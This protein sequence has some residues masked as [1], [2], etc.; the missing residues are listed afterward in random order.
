MEFPR[1]SR[2]RVYV[3]VGMCVR[4]WQ[5]HRTSSD[6]NILPLAAGRRAPATQRRGNA[7]KPKVQI[8]SGSGRR[9]LPRTFGQPRCRVAALFLFSHSR[10]ENMKGGVARGVRLRRLNKGCGRPLSPSSPRLDKQASTGKTA[11]PLR[12]GKQSS[13]KT[14]TTLLNRTERTLMQT[15]VFASV[16]QFHAIETHLTRQ[17][18]IRKKRGKIKTRRRD[19]RA[20]W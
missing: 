16:A 19:A 4:V 7:N 2:A 5:A 6:A 15:R 8:A 13:R 12:G 18:W 3:C 20:V 1:R 9:R 10:R 17:F 14:S 11:R